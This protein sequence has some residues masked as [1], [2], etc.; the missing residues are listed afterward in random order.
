MTGAAA[1]AMGHMERTAA[2]VR[3]LVVEP[4][5]GRGHRLGRTARRGSGS[6]AAHARGGGEPRSRSGRAVVDVGWPADLFAGADGE[7]RLPGRARSELSRSWVCSGRRCGAASPRSP[8]CP[9]RCCA[10]SAGAARKSKP[11]SSATAPPGQR[12]A[13]P[14]PWPRAGAR[15]ARSARNSSKQSGVT[16]PRSSASVL[17][18]SRRCSVVAAS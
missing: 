5:A 15:T 12:P 3:G 17:S 11:S 6:A 13:R 4:A 10:P 1:A 8:V 18:S 16:A 7:L 9:D 14:P 2:A